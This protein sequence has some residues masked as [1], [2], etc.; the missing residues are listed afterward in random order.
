M[1][2]LCSFVK[3]YYKVLENERSKLYNFYNKDSHFLH[4]HGNAVSSGGALVPLPSPRPRLPAARVWCMVISL[5]PPALQFMRVLGVSR[6]LS[7]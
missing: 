1:F 7:R 2:R 4:N 3:Q 5:F 6:T